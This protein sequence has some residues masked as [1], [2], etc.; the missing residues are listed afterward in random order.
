MK[1]K[2]GREEVAG[3]KWG[4]WEQ[5]LAMSPAPLSRQMNVKHA[6]GSGNV[7]GSI[8]VV[9]T[10]C[11]P[12]NTAHF[13]NPYFPPYFT[14]GFSVCVRLIVKTG[15][16]SLCMWVRVVECQDTR[17]EKRKTPWESMLK[18][19]WS[20]NFCKWTKLREQQ[21][22]SQK[23]ANEHN[24][25][26]CLPVKGTSPANYSRESLGFKPEFSNL[27]R[28]TPESAESALVTCS[29]IHSTG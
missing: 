1:A 8:D 27:A 28:S 7:Y 16:M 2:K 4:S 26:N 15:S 17:Q 14:T 6:R 24:F 23:V 18:V 29:L 20:R 22:Q 13:L 19:N 3:R 12:P 9:P 10:H 5:D 21:Q 11:R 25:A